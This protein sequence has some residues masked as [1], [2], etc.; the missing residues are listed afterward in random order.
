[1]F[2]QDA[3]NLN[4]RTLALLAMVP[5]ERHAV[6]LA[7]LPSEVTRALARGQGDQ[8][9]AQIAAAVWATLEARPGKA[10]SHSVLK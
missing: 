1:M 7:H 5:E 9:Q 6:L 3:T 4:P 10:P 8:Y 2:E